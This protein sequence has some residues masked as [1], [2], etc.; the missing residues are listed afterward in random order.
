MNK[1]IVG[2]KDRSEVE[3]KLAEA[4]QMR[5]IIDDLNEKKLVFYSSKR[6]A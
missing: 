2:N 3:T 4:D 5:K 6:I 1:Q